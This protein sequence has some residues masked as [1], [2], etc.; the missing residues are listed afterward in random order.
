ME[1]TRHVTATVYLVEGGATALHEHDRLGI[2]LPPGGHLDRGELP[3]EAALREAREETGLEP[4]LLLDQREVA[5]PT[6]RSIPRPRHLLL[7]DI[8]VCDGAVGHQHVDHVYYAT[9][10]ERRID[11]AP[12]EQGPAAWDWYAP[13]DLRAAGVDPDVRDLG[14][15]A[16]EV[17]GRHGDGA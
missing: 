11:P 7:E 6:A 15:E 9:V 13:D 3:H 12:G 14:L 16:I 8:N 4:D 5:S 1:T 17:A 10:D 2:R